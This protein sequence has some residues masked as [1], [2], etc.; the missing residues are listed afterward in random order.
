MNIEIKNRLF[1]YLT[2][3]IHQVDKNP[4]SWTNYKEYNMKQQS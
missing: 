2:N 1:F 4:Y 3:N